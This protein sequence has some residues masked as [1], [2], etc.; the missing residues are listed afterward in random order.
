M[1]TILIGPED[2]GDIILLPHPRTQEPTQFLLAED[3]GRVHE[4]L[5][6]VG[7]HERSILLPDAVIGAPNHC[8]LATPFDLAFLLIG[9]GETGSTRFVEIDDLLEPWPVVLRP[10][11]RRV[12]PRVAEFLPEDKDYCRLDGNRILSHLRAK[13]DRVRKRL[14]QSLAAATSLD[15]PAEIL[16]SHDERQAVDLVC[17]YLPAATAESLRATYDFGPLVAHEAAAAAAQTTSF[18]DPTE[19]IG[20]RKK[21]TANDNKTAKPKS[22]AAEGLK[23]AN[24]KGM[25]PMTSFFAPKPKRQKT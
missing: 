19:F 17:S 16:Q 13:V 14:P 4:L 24:T 6:L 10:A 1:T 5:D 25:A 18:L 11:L 8:L 3:G 20:Q 15:A 22:R 21:T 12:L 7:P 23:K 2:G 9:A